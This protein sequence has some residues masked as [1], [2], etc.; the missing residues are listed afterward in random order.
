MAPE[1]ARFRRERDFARRAHG[2]PHHHPRGAQQAMRDRRARPYGNRG[3]ACGRRDLTDTAGGMGRLMREVAVANPP[4]E[5]TSSVGYP[6]HE[7]A[8]RN[9]RARDP[10]ERVQYLSFGEMLKDIGGRYRRELPG[11][12]IKNVTVVTVLDPVQARDLGYGHLFQADINSRRVVSFLQHEPDQVSLPAA[13]VE[14]RP[15]RGR[16]QRR[17]DVAAVDEGSS[18]TVSAARVL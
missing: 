18:L 1:R 16:Q 10:I 8:A 2:L 15:R 4:A 14:H 12:R 13:D 17:P 5:W 7:D 3:E 11:S 6:C 9:E